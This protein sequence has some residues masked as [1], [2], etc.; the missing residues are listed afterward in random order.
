MSRL[1]S[2]ILL[3]SAVLAV[4]AFAQGPSD[5]AKAM[6][7]AWE[8]SN[9]ARDKTCPLS[10]SLDPVAGGSKLELD[11]A[12]GT[13]FPALKA[14][15]SWALGP[16]DNVRLMDG[17]GTVVLDFAEVETHM[18]EAERKGEGLYFMRTQAAIKAATISP[19]QLF[20]NW[21][22]L[23]ELDKPLCKL[24]L[25]GASAGEQTFRINVAAG[26]AA[27]IAGLGLE[28]WR[29]D[30]DELILIG[31]GATW[32]FLES[33]SKTWERIPPSTDPM[34]LMRQ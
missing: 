18:Y 14:V 2:S 5:A 12:C 4:P 10:F 15:A 8:I 23:Q 22:L 26:C 7:G 1:H 16:N 24:T 34:V 20:G 31:R 19:E 25:S 13:V 29:L 32:R 28:T 3:L 17:R 9:A 6:V 27:P 11:G 21:T 30:S 33:D